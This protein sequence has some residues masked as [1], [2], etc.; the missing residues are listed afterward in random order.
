MV[1]GLGYGRPSL[2]GESARLSCPPEL[3]QVGPNLTMCTGNGRW[4]PDPIK[5]A[6]KGTAHFLVTDI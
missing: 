1:S 6:C 4:E 5:V 2:E 3:V